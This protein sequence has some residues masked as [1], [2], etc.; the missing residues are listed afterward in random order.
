MKTKKFPKYIFVTV[1]SDESADSND[2]YFLVAW[3]DLPE[4]DGDS[5]ATYE[6]KRTGKITVTVSARFEE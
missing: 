5:V 1:D 4:K 2:K 3:D 6:L